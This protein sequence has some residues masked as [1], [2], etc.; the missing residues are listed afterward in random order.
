MTSRYVLAYDKEKLGE[1]ASSLIISGFDPVQQVRVRYPAGDR[2]RG[3][4]GGHGQHRTRGV[5][6]GE[7][8]RGGEPV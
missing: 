3:R 4:V 7:R 1:S 6:V 5:R 2:C 8:P